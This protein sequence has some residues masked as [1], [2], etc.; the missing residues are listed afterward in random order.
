MTLHSKSL[1][2]PS[3]ALLL[4]IP[5]HHNCTIGTFNK[6][7]SALYATRKSTIKTK[8]ILYQLA[9]LKGSNYSNGLK[10]YVAIEDSS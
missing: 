9:K 3:L 7:F 4:N 1:L 8:L 10:G 5:I 6:E 2:H